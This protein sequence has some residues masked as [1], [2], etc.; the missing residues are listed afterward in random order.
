MKKPITFAICGCG[1][2]G[3][4]AY[5]SYQ[6]NAPNDMKIVAAADPDPAK[7]D[8][9]HEQFHV[10]YE[11]IFETDVDLLAQDRLADV[12][13][14]ATQDQDHVR[15][16]LL[17]MEKG[18]HI[19]LEKPISP[20]PIECLQLEEKCR[21]TNCLVVVCHV[22]RYT[23]FYQTIKN[24]ISSG[25]IGELQTIDAI[26]HVAY[27]HFAHSYVRGNWR[28]EAEA[29]PSI[30][31]KSCHD[32][33]II[34][35]LMDA[36]CERIQSF[37]GLNVFTSEKAPDKAAKR[38]LDCPIQDS[39][40][41]DAEKIYISNPASGIRHK[42][43]VWPLTVL[44]NDPN[45]EKIYSAL[46]DGP[47]G[48][49]VYH[50]DNDVCDHQTVNMEFANRAKATFTMTAFT[51]E[52]YR[53]IEVTG[54]LGQIVGNMESNEIELYRF[55]QEK[56]IIQLNVSTNEFAGHGGGD[57][58]MMQELIELVSQDNRD[59]LTSVEKSVESHMLAFAAEASRK[60]DGETLTMGAFREEILQGK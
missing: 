55:G 18:Y 14:I 37:G 13:I 17:A 43:K 21:E 34:R 19:L 41:Y 33:D 27:W 3:L 28:K 22:L 20:S 4:E 30:L 25:A 9:V 26:E 54:S 8:I 24:I 45:E 32:L 39:C 42:G 12:L 51:E 23:K 36:P 10:P 29:S 48:R 57:H 59:A 47:Y 31:A 38:C 6:F 2:R 50:S 16:A 1:I 44:D 52:C 7:R 53:T 11:N 5:A 60:K 40:P 58:A 15:Q 56:E 35:W 49:C 46:Q